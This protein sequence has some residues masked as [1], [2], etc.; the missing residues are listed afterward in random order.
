MTFSIAEKIECLEREVKLRVRVYKNRILTGR[1]S[2]HKA[3]HETECMRE[4]LL[5]YQSKRDRERLL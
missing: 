3:T 1:M 2:I 5:D 4:I